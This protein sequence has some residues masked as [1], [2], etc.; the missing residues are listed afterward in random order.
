MR[1][2]VLVVHPGALGDVVIALGPASRLPGALWCAARGPAL[3]L[4]GRVSN[5]AGRLDLDGAHGPVLLGQ[6]ADGR[7]L[8]LDGLE[9][10][11]A[12]CR[13]PD[14]A[15][16]DRL[17]RAFG[18]PVVAASALPPDGSSA[19]GHVAG[20][21]GVS[22]EPMGCPWISV[23]GTARRAS[24][25]LVHP[26]SGGRAKRW[27]LRAFEETAAVL[28][29]HGLRVRWVLG[30]AEID[31]GLATEAAA[32]VLLRPSIDALAQELAGVAVYLGNDSGVS[33]LA[34]A[35]GTPSV[36]VFGPTAPEVWAPAAGW[37]TAVRG[38]PALDPASWGLDP[39][40][41]AE[42]VLAAA[43]G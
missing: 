17:S 31:D 36:L 5:V 29:A 38:D 22:T 33:H 6:R 28:A 21:L 41:I 23:P 3:R 37:V 1:P 39:A 10:V 42:L 13:D 9:A 24:T 2:A 7:P 32:G 34:A 16:Q 14:G 20:M 40:R 12:L 25:V 35:V 30:D 8:E 43:R 11:F 26:G 4:A 19:H 27:P 18:V 15:I